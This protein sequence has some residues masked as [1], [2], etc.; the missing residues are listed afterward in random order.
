MRRYGPALVLSQQRS[1]SAAFQL[2]R[3]CPFDS[4]RLVKMDNAL[5]LRLMPLRAIEINSQAGTRSLVQFSFP[6]RPSRKQRPEPTAGG[7]IDQAVD[8]SSPP[9][10]FGIASCQLINQQFGICASHPPLLHHAYVVRLYL[11][12]QR[13][14]SAPA[15]PDAIK[16]SRRVCRPVFGPLSSCSK[17]SEIAT[18]RCL[19]R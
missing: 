19:L 14:L 2:G 18:N 12:T 16:Q 5:D 7:T 4:W 15:C 13:E 3:W 11:Q 1:R 17:M 8:T 6:A 9:E 10:G